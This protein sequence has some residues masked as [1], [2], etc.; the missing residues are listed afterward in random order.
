MTLFQF[1]GHIFLNNGPILKI[2]KLG[3]SWQCPLSGHCPHGRDSGTIRPKSGLSRRN[4]DTWHV[5]LPDLRTSTFNENWRKITHQGTKQAHR[6]IEGPARLQVEL[7]IFSRRSC[8]FDTL[9][10]CMLELFLLGKKH[11]IQQV[12]KIVR[13]T[14]ACAPYWQ[15]NMEACC[16]HRVSVLRTSGFLFLWGARCTDRNRNLWRPRVAERGCASS[17]GKNR[18]LLQYVMQIIKCA[19]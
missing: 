17:A 7:N 12:A 6:S 8:T 5:W 11:S 15:S 1:F 16:L 2:K 3:C 19:N 4:R 13:L 18:N 9:N 14:V 10:T